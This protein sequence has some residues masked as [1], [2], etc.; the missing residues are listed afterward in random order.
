MPRRRRSSCG[1]CRR[2]RRRSRR[3]C[4]GDAVD[5]FGDP[6]ERVQVAQPALAVLDVVLDEVA[7]AAD[8]AVTLLALGELGGDELRGGALHDL[9]VEARHE[10]VVELAVAEQ[11]A[12]LEQ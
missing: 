12:R 11:E 4:G 10:L 3:W 2:L 6:E 8:A 7:R 5:V 1:L 9:L